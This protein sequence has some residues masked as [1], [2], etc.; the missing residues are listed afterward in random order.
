M[1]PAAWLLLSALIHMRLI[2]WKVPSL[3]FLKCNMCRIIMKNKSLSHMVLLPR[4]SY[5]W[6]IM[7]TETHVTWCL[8]F[9]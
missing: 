9:W 4:V 3:G 8:L 2:L 5:W 1:N 6:L 7:K